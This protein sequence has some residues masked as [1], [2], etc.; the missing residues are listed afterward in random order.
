VKKL[1]NKIVIHFDKERLKNW[2]RKG[3]V[4]IA[5]KFSKS[6]NFYICRVCK[7]MLPE[8]EMNP[9]DNSICKECSKD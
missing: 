7:H 3:R 4:K 8:K 1:I 5:K 2:V 6:D 9:E